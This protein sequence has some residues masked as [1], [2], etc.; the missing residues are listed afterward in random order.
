MQTNTQVYTNETK[1][2]IS[3][4]LQHFF[5]QQQNAKNDLPGGVHVLLLQDWMRSELLAGLDW[6]LST[7][8]AKGQQ[9][10]NITGSNQ[11]TECANSRRI[12]PSELDDTHSLNLIFHISMHHI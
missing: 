11:S 7:V 6:L 12:Y 4:S 1:S 9:G 5:A 8:K 10:H 2:W 3:E